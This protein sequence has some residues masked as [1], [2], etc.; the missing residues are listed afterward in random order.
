MSTTPLLPPTAA[1]FPL[2][3]TLE[4]SVAAVSLAAGVAL[5]PAPAPGV[6]CGPESTRPYGMRLGI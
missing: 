5:R 2:P 3:G 4:V 6:A 1:I